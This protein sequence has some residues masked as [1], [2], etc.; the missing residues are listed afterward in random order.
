[1]TIKDEAE[2][3]LDFFHDEMG[4]SDDGQRP[5]YYI[6]GKN[7]LTWMEANIG[8]YFA[9]VEW[10]GYFIKF[11]AQSHFENTGL[12]AKESVGKSH[13]LRGEKITWDIRI[14]DVENNP[15]VILNHVNELENAI[16]KDGSRG[17]IVL[18]AHYDLDDD[19]GNFQL[20]QEKMKGGKSPV[21]LRYRKEGRP[22]RRRKT[23]FI[24]YYGQAILITQQDIDDPPLWLSS[25]RPGRNSDKKPR[26]PKYLID[27]ENLD[28]QGEITRK[29]F[30]LDRDEFAEYFEDIS[31]P[32]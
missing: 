27:L 12:L 2:A 14:H 9:E 6:D 13:L 8:A 29:N 25:Y 24:L 15:I 10:A 3:I 5:G 31:F 20:F 30:N 18:H 23:G 32:R 7:A 11:I 16:N 19:T 1:M 21:E 17:I 22:T 4:Q 26:K 28:V